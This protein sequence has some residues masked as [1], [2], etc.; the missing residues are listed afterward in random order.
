MRTLITTFFCIVFLT[1][2]NPAN[3]QVH[4]P[5][6]VYLFYTEDCFSCEGILQGYLPSLKSLYPSLEVK[7]FDIAN[8]THHEA[9]IKFEKQFGRTGNDFPVAFIGDQILAGGQEIMERLD[10]LILEY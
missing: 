1:L 8:P 9:L 2:P 4:S 3:T 7:T 5:V 6:Q 10:P